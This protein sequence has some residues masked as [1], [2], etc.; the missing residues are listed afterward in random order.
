[1]RGRPK[2]NLM[3]ELG[4]GSGD[5]TNPLELLGGLREG[6][7]CGKSVGLREVYER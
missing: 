6:W 5:T 3:H 4:S 7:A 2:Q 1:M